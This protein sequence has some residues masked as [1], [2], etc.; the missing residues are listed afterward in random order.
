[1]GQFKESF[2]LSWLKIQKI[3]II[4]NTKKSSNIYCNIDQSQRN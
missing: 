2:K 1:M 3:T 4:K